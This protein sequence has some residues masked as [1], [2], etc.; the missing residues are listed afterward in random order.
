MIVARIIGLT[1]CVF[2]R[3][4]SLIVNKS[5]MTSSSLQANVH[6]FPPCMRQ[7]VKNANMF[8]LQ[9]NEVIFAIELQ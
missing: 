5:S 8:R 2:P 6:N 4:Q 1:S 7:I 9:N 3:R